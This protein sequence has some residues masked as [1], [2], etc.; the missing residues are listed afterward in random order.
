M[1]KRSA[2]LIMYRYKKEVLEIFLVHMGG[3]YWAKKDF[4]AWSIPKGEYRE[5]ADPLTAAKREFLEETGFHAEGDFKQLT[6][7]GQ[8]SGKEIIAWAFEGNCDA[9]SIRSNTFTLEWPPGCGTQVEFPEVDRAEWFTVDLAKNKLL[10]GQA[11]FIEELC[12]V[13]DY[14]GPRRP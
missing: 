11:G 1:K 14:R 12:K 4:G 3:P 2:G 10:K 5:R 8:P 7:L 13:L 9:S 6:T